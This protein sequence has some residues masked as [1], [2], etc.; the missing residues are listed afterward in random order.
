MC[1][2]P[3]FQSKLCYFSM[4]IVVC[5]I[6]IAKFIVKVDRVTI[7]GLGYLKFIYL[8]SIKEG[9]FIQKNHLF[10][11]DTLVKEKIINGIWAKNVCPF[12]LAFMFQI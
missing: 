12:V 7:T 1:L 3:P 11:S 9:S 2:Q 4:D 10:R 5:H 6:F 8:F